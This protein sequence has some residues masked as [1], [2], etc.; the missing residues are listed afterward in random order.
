MNDGM[1]MVSGME[2][3]HWKGVVLYP[4]PRA[5]YVTSYQNLNNSNLHPNLHIYCICFYSNVLQ[6]TYTPVVEAPAPHSGRIAGPYI[7]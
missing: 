4:S 1:H 7:P 2:W 6:F 5:S 3:K